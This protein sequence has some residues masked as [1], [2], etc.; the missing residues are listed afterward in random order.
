MWKGNKIAEIVLEFRIR[1]S[2]KTQ[3]KRKI[4]IGKISFC[5]PL[6]S[7]SKFQFGAAEFD[8]D[9]IALEFE[10][11]KFEI[12][13]FEGIEFSNAWISMLRIL[14]IRIRVFGRQPNRTSYRNY[15][16]M[17]DILKIQFRKRN[18]LI[19]IWSLRKFDIKTITYLG[20]EPFHGIFFSQSTGESYF[21]TFS[22]SVGDIITRIQIRK[23]EQNWNKR[24]TSTQHFRTYLVVLVQRR[25][26]N[27]KFR[28]WDRIWFLNRY[29][30]GYRIQNY[31]CRKNCLLNSYSVT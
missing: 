7:I 26:P 11:S 28:Y 16:F 5:P 30:L 14:K 1:Q 9:F 18:Y 6:F 12:Q 25:S 24:K 22:S 17:V 13:T 29:V 10:Y 31:Q 19:W 2:I 20:L 27:H 4:F 21:A 15:H 3:Q 23:L 8:L